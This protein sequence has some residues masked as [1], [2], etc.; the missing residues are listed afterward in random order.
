M[1]NNKNKEIM[2]IIENLGYKIA[3]VKKE[4]IFVICKNNV[5]LIINLSE[6]QLKNDLNFYNL[7]NNKENKKRII[8]DEICYKL[9]NIIKW[10]A[11]IFG[12][13]IN[14]EEMK[15]QDKEIKKYQENLNELKNQTIG[16]I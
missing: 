10:K 3:D 6:K 13:G 14:E 4:N 11:E 1:T 12:V 8:I 9:N 7:E 5:N 15:E 2:A 16:L